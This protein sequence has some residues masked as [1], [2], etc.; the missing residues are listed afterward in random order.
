VDRVANTE[1]SRRL[2]SATYPDTD[3]KFHLDIEPERD[4]VRVCP[5]G[6]VDLTTTDAIRETFEELSRR[7]FRRVVLDLR[8]VTFLD[9]TGV[10]LALELLESSRTA[11]WEFAVVDGPTPVRRIF[12]LTGVRSVIPFIAP[13]QIRYSRWSPA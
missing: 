13:T 2:M 12:E 5:H 8:G 7:G 11:E 3:H 9:S 4:A 6:E 10:R 1:V